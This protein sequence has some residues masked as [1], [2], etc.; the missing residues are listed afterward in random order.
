MKIVTTMFL[1]A[2]LALTA[3]AQGP[4][5]QFK[6][7]GDRLE[8]RNLATVE[9]ETEFETFI[10]KTTKVSGSITF[11]PR[12]RVGGGSISVDATS[13]DTGIA[14]RNEHMRG[15]QWLNTGKNPSIR[16]E[17]T[18]VEPLAGEQYRVTGRFTLNGVTRT[19]TA[20]ARLRFRQAGEQTR[21]AG[22]EGDV[23]QVSTKFDIRLSDYGIRIPA[24]TSGKVNNTVAI[25]I[26]VYATAN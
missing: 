5:K 11:D 15:E 3:A 13:I 26:S 16:F 9:S 24:A 1:V 12:T 10:G 8:F 6:I 2:A 21:A 23:V 25:G 4:A 7:V 20:N 22:F 17:A 18:R 19:V 14:L